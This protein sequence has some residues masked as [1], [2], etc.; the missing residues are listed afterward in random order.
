METFP[1]EVQEIIIDT[2]FEMGEH[3]SEVTS[4]MEKSDRPKLFMVDGILQ[5]PFVSKKNL[6]SARKL[7]PRDDDV[8]VVT[9][10]KSGTTWNLF[11]CLNL[12]KIDYMEGTQE[13]FTDAPFL[14][15]FPLEVLDL[16][17][18]Q[19]IFKT[20]FF[21]DWIPKSKKAKYIYTV[22]NP[23][24]VLISY[25]HHIRNMKIND[26]EDG[27]FNVMFEMFLN[28]EIESGGYFMHVKSWLPHI[29]DENVLF[30]VYEDMC[31]DLKSNIIKIAKFLGGNANRI[32]EDSKLLDKVV[33]VC[34]FKSMHEKNE[35]FSSDITMR[36]KTF[37]RKGGSKNWKNYLTKEQSDL[38]DKKF[39]EYFKGTI[40]ENLWI[41]EMSW[42]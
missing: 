11:I 33:D 37:I 2:L 29:N 31:K 36:T 42:N 26:W 8:F 23:K 9:T 20:H 35:I 16:F 7:V 25:Y 13:M 19:R 18:V 24:D 6:R 4:V 28:D 17:P 21:Y 3:A 30:L 10:P 32:L 34:T 14:E 5:Q 38:I 1:K 39:Y 40:L 27:D 22:R 12:L 15:S 41:D